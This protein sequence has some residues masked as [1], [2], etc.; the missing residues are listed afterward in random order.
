M[1]E[2]WKPIPSYEGVYEVSDMGR[3]R[4]LDRAVAY[5]R[6]GNTSYKGRIL[7][8]RP[9]AKGYPLVTLAVKGVVKPVYVHH[10]VLLAFVGER[11]ETDARS[12]IRHL[13]GDK[14]NNSLDN[15]VY[16]TIH[17]NWDDRRRH[18]ERD[19]A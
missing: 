4:S 1:N 3:V 17:E 14:T 12:E 16:G 10:L 9:T 2:I 18:R 7:K 15:L 11:P 8:T 6:F 19:A 13:D 5:G